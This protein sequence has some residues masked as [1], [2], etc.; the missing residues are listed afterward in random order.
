MLL[1]LA[2]CDEPTAPSPGPGIIRR[3][4]LWLDCLSCITLSGYARLPAMLPAIRTRCALL[5]STR[6]CHLPTRRT[7]LLGCICA[8]TGPTWQPSSSQQHCSSHHLAGALHSCSAALFLL[9]VAAACSESISPTGNSGRPRRLSVYT[10]LHT[11]YTAAKFACCCCHK[12]Y[13]CCRVQN[14]AKLRA[15]LICSC[16]SGCNLCSECTG[17]NS[18]ALLDLP[19]PTHPHI[20]RPV[21]AFCAS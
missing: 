7:G 13:R 3:G 11:R 6:Q 18:G 10:T 20:G 15:A 17:L 12:R 2:F 5:G 21:H 16:T 4:C 9:P 19:P 8:A 14:L 1:Q